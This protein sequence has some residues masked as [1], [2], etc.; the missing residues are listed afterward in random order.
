MDAAALIDVFAQCLPQDGS[1]L[2]ILI[3]QK[4]RRLTQDAAHQFAPDRHREAFHVHVATAKIIDDWRQCFLFFLLPVH[5]PFL[6]LREGN[7][8]DFVPRLGAADDISLAG[9]LII[10]FFNGHLAD[11]GPLG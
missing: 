5:R 10:G 4:V 9:K 1:P 2:L 3:G 8:G 6:F 11:A 7:I